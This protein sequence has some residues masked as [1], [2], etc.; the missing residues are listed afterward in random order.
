[1]NT[2]KTKRADWRKV[3]FIVF[4]V[5][6]VFSL[7][8]AACAPAEGLE[9]AGGKGKGDEKGKGPEDKGPDDKGPDDKGP[10]DKGPKEKPT[11]KPKDK[12]KEKTP[13]GGHTPV[14]ICHATG[15]ATNPYVKITV[16]DDGAYSGHIYHDGDIIPAPAGGCP[17]GDKPTKT[18][19]VNQKIT[20]CHATGSAKNPYVKITVADDGVYN[21]HIKHPDD[22]I[23]APAGGCPVP[24]DTPTDTPTPTGTPPT[25]TDT[26]PPTPTPPPPPP[27]IEVEPKPFA[28]VQLIVFHTFR[29]GDLEIF[30]LDGSEEDSQANLI[31]LSNSSATDS[32]P[33]R[34][35]ND[36]Q[37]VFQSDRDGNVELYLGDMQG[38]SQRR[39]TN[40]QSNN[41]NA[42]AG[43]DNQSVIYQS[44]R[45]GNWD[46]YIVDVASGEERQLTDSAWDDV[47][48]F[49]S[50]DEDWITF[51]SNRTGSWNIYLLNVSTAN[52]Y[53][54]T[55]FV[56]VDAIFPAW[57]PNGAQLSFLS[58]L[59]GAWD[60]F[61]ANYD[62]SGIEQITT[63]GGAGNATWSPEG[64]RIAYQVDNEDSL[65]VYT[66]DLVNGVE[67]QL[68]DFTGPDSAPTWDCGG[69]NVAYTSLLAGN[70]DIFSVPWQGGEISV[71][72]NDQSTD[73]W[74]QWSP[75]KEPASRGY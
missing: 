20:I 42:M 46:I 57:S 43:P 2:T 17:K 36:S 8:L 14:T 7:L 70:P 27:D 31:N 63:D 66:Y 23:P 74:S 34:F 21:G 37:I 30:R 32:R 5:T 52:E 69:G 39:L 53:T 68:T 22:I 4:A 49:W 10:D 44:D 72:T 24:T 54:V 16:D 65:D 11:D 33:S 15:S 64:Y 67:Y 58:N 41:I 56:G 26:P 1:M 40:T 35:P 18:P 9:G 59:N 25:P 12:P 55:E 45:N 50:P 29:T 75:S 19:K 47:N 61:V 13:G 6:L 60:L 38:K 3:L 71:I 62:G 48:P 51:Q 73:K 28:C